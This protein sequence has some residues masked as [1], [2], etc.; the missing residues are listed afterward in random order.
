MEGYL[1]FLEIKH[2]SRHPC[3]VFDPYFT[4][5]DATRVIFYK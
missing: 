4:V 5:K 3:Y 1:R 2:K